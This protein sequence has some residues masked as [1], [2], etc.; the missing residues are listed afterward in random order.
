MRDRSPEVLHLARTILD[1]SNAAMAR[2]AGG[3]PTAFDQASVAPE[4]LGILHGA[5]EL[6]AFFDPPTAPIEYHGVPEA[7]IEFDNPPHLVLRSEEGF[8]FLPWYSEKA[9]ALMKEA[10]RAVSAWHRG[11]DDIRLRPDSSSAAE[12]FVGDLMRYLEGVQAYAQVIFDMTSE[13]RVMVQEIGFGP[14]DSN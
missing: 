12:T 9:A 10:M 11:L 3:S 13:R 14:E 4:L 8:N 2:I 6:V 7:M 1:Q 5:H